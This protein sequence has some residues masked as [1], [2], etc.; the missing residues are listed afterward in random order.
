MRIYTLRAC[1]LIG[2]NAKTA[3]ASCGN[4]T[5]HCGRHSGSSMAMRDVITKLFAIT[6]AFNYLLRLRG[7]VLIVKVWLNSS[8]KASDRWW[9]SCNESPIIACHFAGCSLYL[10]HQK[11]ANQ[12]C[13]HNS[14]PINLFILYFIFPR[15]IVESTVVSG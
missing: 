15:V 10:L 14:M 7:R 6:I 4:R 9:I 1:L 12:A 8:E 5:K 2:A 11:Y 3:S 13:M